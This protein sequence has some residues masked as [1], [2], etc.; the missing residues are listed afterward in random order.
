VLLD[1][2]ITLD[3]RARPFQYVET[4]PADFLSSL[5]QTV[6]LVFQANESGR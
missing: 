2:L 1:Q 6:V 3:Y 4:V 5:L